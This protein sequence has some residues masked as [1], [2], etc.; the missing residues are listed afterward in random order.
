MLLGHARCEFFEARTNDAI[1]A[2]LALV[3]IGKLYQIEAHC[4]ENR[5]RPVALGRKNYLFAG[6]HDGAQRAAMIY[7][8]FAMCKTE[9]VNPKH[10][11]KYVFDNI[12][13]T[14]IQKIEQLLPKNYKLSLAENQPK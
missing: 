7:S 11:L 14:N 13:E 1:R 5:I 12:M 3:F 9:E 6:S 4:R 10:W 8:F 2:E